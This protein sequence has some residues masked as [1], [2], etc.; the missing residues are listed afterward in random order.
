MLALQFGK[1]LPLK[2]GEHVLYLRRRRVFR[3]HRIEFVYDLRFWYVLSRWG[4]C[5][6]KLPSGN[7]L[8]RR[9]EIVYELRFRHIF[10]FRVERVHRLRIGHIQQWEREYVFELRFRL[11]LYD[12]CKCVLALWPR[13]V[14]LQFWVK[15]VLDLPGRFVL[16]LRWE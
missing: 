3:Q 16:R 11:I 13:Y 9:G 14:L 1:V 8:R 6:L 4:K 5:V 10:C 7:L 2:R 15:H 12:K